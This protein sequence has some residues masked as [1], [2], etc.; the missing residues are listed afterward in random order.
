MLQSITIHEISIPSACAQYVNTTST[1][2]ETF[3]SCITLMISENHELLRAFDQGGGG[4][5][6]G[7]PA[8]NITI[9][10]PNANHVLGEY[11]STPTC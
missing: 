2:K 5:G 1:Y 7:I 11:N 6:G 4:G 3:P 8:I 10:S 9:H